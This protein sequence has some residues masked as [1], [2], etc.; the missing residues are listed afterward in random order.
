MKP[1]ILFIFIFT[2]LVA[3]TQ[4]K[5]ISGQIIKSGSLQYHYFIV[6]LKH[7][8]SIIQEAVPDAEGRFTLNDVEKGFY[9]L[10][11]KRPFREDYLADSL[12]VVTDNPVYLNIYP[13][14]QPKGEIPKCVGGHTDQI[15][16]IVYGRP[17]AETMTNAKE[18][19]VR[20]GG[21][22][23]T[24]CDPNYYCTLHKIEL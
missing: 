21:C 16:P 23:V 5:Q 9:N 11:V 14:F 18:G 7:A 1:I 19:L 22:M 4:K 8:G 6:S 2:S 10:I 12:L 24:G 20:I 17:I 13:C 15:I 3:F